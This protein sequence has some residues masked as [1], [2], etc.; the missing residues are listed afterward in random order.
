MGVKVKKRNGAWWIFVNFQ[1]RRK[2]KKIGS[3]EAAEK[4][5]RALEAKL[6]L[7]DITCFS[8]S[9]PEPT[10]NEYVEKWLKT[11]AL[12][13]KASTVDFYRDYQKRYVLPRFGTMKLSAIDRD[14]IKDFMSALSEK[15]LA[16]NTIRLAIASLRV[17][18]SSAVEDKKLANNPALRLGRF[19]ESHKREHEAQAMEPREVERF[20]EAIRE[21]G[22]EYYALF[23]I[24]LRA[25]LRQGEILALRWGDFQFGISEND[26]NRFIL[27]QHR[28]Y[29]GKFGT[30]K[31]NRS[32]R[33]DMSQDLRSALLELRDQRMLE[34][35][36]QGNA[37]I[38]DAIVFRGASS[39][40]PI[41]VRYLS[42]AYFLPAL[43]RAGLRRFRFHDMRHTFG[44]LLIESG[45]PLPYVKDQMGHSSIQ[46]TADKYVH[47]VPG[48]HVG[49]VDRLASLATA[50]PNATQ[51]QPATHGDDGGEVLSASQMIEGKGWCER[52]DSNPHGF[53]RQILSLVR[54]P[55]PPLSHFPWAVAHRCYDA[56]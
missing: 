39:E 24:A 16:R 45:A 36:Q 53:T 4:V 38:A 9:K 3:R 34:A 54:L 33:V 12:R 47:L 50:Q 26:P 35:F 51:A 8:E 31:G 27:V 49:F 42:E 23:L 46:I 40:A 14:K 17:V 5:Q 29:R 30:P 43:E 25:G 11:D 2:A 32:R 15:G 10:L 22:V 1:G 28:W 20:L 56:P 48:R 7:G 44:S 52:G 18:L 13:C 37:S 6:A 41:S 55:I 19:I 21:S